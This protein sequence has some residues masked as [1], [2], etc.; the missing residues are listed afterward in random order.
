M[1][2]QHAAG[3]HPDQAIEEDVTNEHMSPSELLAANEADLREYNRMLAR[4]LN[5]DIDAITTNFDRILPMMST[6]HNSMPSLK[7][8]FLTAQ[9]DTKRSAWLLARAD[10]R[11]LPPSTHGQAIRWELLYHWNNFK[12]FLRTKRGFRFRFG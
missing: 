5:A 10:G 6:I 12:L 8:M 4:R 9:R 2:V 3:E 1:D 11:R 7:R